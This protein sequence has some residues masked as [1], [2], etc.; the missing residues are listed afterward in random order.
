MKKLILSLVLCASLLGCGVNM[1]TPAGVELITDKAFKVSV[2]SLNA[3]YMFGT[4]SK[5]DH[6]AIKIYVDAA[7]A[8]LQQYHDDL[9]AGKVGSEIAR[10]LNA[11]NAAAA[12]VISTE[13]KVHPK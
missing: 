13:A 12:V 7:N 8:A 5:A 2:D 11:F 4:F 9:K 3:A 6:D 10:D 1:N